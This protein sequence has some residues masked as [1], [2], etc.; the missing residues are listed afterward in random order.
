MN[1]ILFKHI[2]ITVNNVQFNKSTSE[3]GNV[4]TYSNYVGEIPKG[5]GQW[6]RFNITKMFSDWLQ[7]IE[8]PREHFAC[9]IFLKSM[10]PWTRRLIALDIKTMMVMQY[11]F[12]YFS[13]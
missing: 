1:D 8:H 13:H 5:V 4:R 12:I 6:I 10:H 9:D 2:S 3:L 11:E 7:T